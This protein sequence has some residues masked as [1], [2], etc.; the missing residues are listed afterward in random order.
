MLTY[1]VDLFRLHWTWS[2][3]YFLIYFPYASIIIH[4]HII[5]CLYIP[6]NILFSCIYAVHFIMYFHVNIIVITKIIN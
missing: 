1:I 6:Q 3:C 2:K 5:L 4:L